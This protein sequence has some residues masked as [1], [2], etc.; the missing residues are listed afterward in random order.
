MILLIFLGFKM[1]NIEGKETIRYRGYEKKTER[2]I[3]RSVWF[4]DGLVCATQ[5]HLDES[6]LFLVVK[7]Y[8]DSLYTS[9]VEKHKKGRLVLKE[10]REK[11][12]IKVNLEG[13]KKEVSNPR[14]FD[15]HTL[16][17]VLRFYDFE[18]PEK[19]EIPLYVPEYKTVKA[20]VEYV[21]ID[22][23]STPLGKIASHRLRLRILGLGGLISRLIG[24]PLDFDFWYAKDYPHYLVKFTDGKQGKIII[25]RIEEGR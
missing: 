1:F 14:V 6:N 12:K 8:Q 4:E 7:V 5:A 22:T 17:E 9:Y 3:L 13:R 2:D 10:K 24:R 21:G 18:N 23:V 25:K 11:G 20:S 19:M 15:R 16:F